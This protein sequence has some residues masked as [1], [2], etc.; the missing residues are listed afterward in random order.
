MERHYRGTGN[1]EDRQAA[2]WA[3][4]PVVDPDV[5]NHPSGYLAPE[6]LVAAVHVALELGMPLLLT[7]EPGCG[8][9]RLA[10]SVA[11]ELGFPPLP[12]T[13]PHLPPEERYGEP[14]RFPVKSDTESRD[15]FYRFDT[16]GRFHAAH[17]GQLDAD[18]R[19]FVTYQALGKAI[20]IAK[21]R[22]R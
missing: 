14:L 9:S 15:L 2:R 17:G 7:G 18:A 20:L 3:K 10:Y 22:Q 13:Q 19:R 16:L 4:L 21:G 1:P 12:G 5:L 11:W 8:K 6:G